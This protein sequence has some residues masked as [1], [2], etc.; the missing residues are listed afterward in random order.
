MR[1]FIPFTLDINLRT[2][3][4]FWMSIAALE[5]QIRPIYGGVFKRINFRRSDTADLT[6]SLDTGS[7]KIALATCNKLRKKYPQNTLIKA[8]YYSKSLPSLTR[9]CLGV[10]IL[11]SGSVAKIWRSHRSM[12][13]RAIYQD[14]WRIDTVCD[15]ARTSWIRQAFV[16]HQEFLNP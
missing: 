1:Q 6:D 14:N 13:W 4:W 16:H 2:R 10:E 3:S 15:A 12:R 11:G 5:R 7:P 8:R 9:I